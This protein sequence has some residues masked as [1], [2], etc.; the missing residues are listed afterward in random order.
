MA[1]ATA[2]DN[3][4]SVRVIDVYYEDGALLHRHPL[5]CYEEFFDAP[6]GDKEFSAAIL[7]FSGFSIFLIFKYIAL[8]VK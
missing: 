7:A 5:I 8:Y 6:A 1:L 3:K 4:P 2:R